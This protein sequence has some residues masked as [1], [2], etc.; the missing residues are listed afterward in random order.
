MDGAKLITCI[1][2][3]GAGSDLVRRLEAEH[4]IVATFTG[5]ARSLGSGADPE[6]AVACEVVNAVV[7]ADRAD[8]LFEFAWDAAGIGR[9]GGGFLYQSALYGA[10]PFEL[11]EPA[12]PADAMP[13]VD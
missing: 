4:G 6:D 8:A 2:P 13:D 3:P 9:P 11:R 10:S 7:P 12:P 1:V 5:G